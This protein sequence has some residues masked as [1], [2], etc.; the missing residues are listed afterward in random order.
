MK[1]EVK[2]ALSEWA[3]GAL[4]GAIPLC[5]HGCAW[6]VFQT[7]DPDRSLDMTTEL[8]FGAI[9]TSA[10][11]PISAATRLMKGSLDLSKLG[12]RALV[13]IAL[14]VLL[15]VLAAMSYGAIATGTANVGLWK[16]ALGLFV[17]ALFLSLMLEFT[18][19][20]ALIQ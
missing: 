7:N 20:A 2:G 11:G 3:A 13:L 14:A 10:T 9:A 8:V 15:L 19:A 12:R 6:V 17:A 5:A 16:W 1:Q 4:V 18:V